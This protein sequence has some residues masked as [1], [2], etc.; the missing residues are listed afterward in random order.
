MLLYFQFGL[1]SGSGELLQIRMGRSFLHTK[2]GKQSAEV[3]LML[4]VVSWYTTDPACRAVLHDIT[5]KMW[6]K[7]TQVYNQTCGRSSF[8]GRVF[9]LKCMQPH[10]S[11]HLYAHV[12]DNEARTTKRFCLEVTWNC[13]WRTKCTREPD[14]NYETRFALFSLES[15]VWSLWSFFEF[16]V[17]LISFC[18]VCQHLKCVFC[19]V[20]HFLCSSSHWNGVD[21]FFT[22]SISHASS[23]NWCQS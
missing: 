8:L 6:L 15:F 1:Q 22:G 2:P 16:V 11:A 7:A 13:L 18:C 21:P 4:G 23:P 19:V 10:A 20:L 3:V 17:T 14:W 12:N 9:F 5:G